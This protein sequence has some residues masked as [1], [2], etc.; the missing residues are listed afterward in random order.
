MSIFDIFRKRKKIPTPWAKYYNDEELD[1]KI[2]NIS[3][4]KQLSI[5]ANR[6]PNNIAYRYLGR[7]VSYKKF[8]KQIDT[9]AI[10]FKKMEIKKGDVVTICLPNLP[11]A[12]IAFYALNKLG[13][14]ASMIHPLSAE[15]EIK[16]SVISTKSKYL[17]ILDMFYDKVKNTIKGTK[18]RNVIFASASNSMSL[19]LKIGYKLINIGKLKKYPRNDF[20]MSW[21][22]FINKSKFS[23]LEIKDKYGK[24]TP[25]VILHSGGTSGK[26]KN[27]VLQ[28]RSF[29]MS[30]IQEGVCLKIANVGDSILAI[31][32]NFH[33]FGLSVCMH[34]VMTLGITSI[35]VPQFD[36][37]KFDVLF[38]K[39]KP[40]IVVGVPTL[41]E[42]LISNNNVKKLD[43]SYLKIAISG[44]DMLSK[45]LEDRVNNYFEEHN[46]DAKITQG[47]GMTEALAAVCLGIGDVS[48]SG[49]IG[50]PLPGNHIKIINPSTRKTNPYNV[51]GEI[52]INTKALMMGYLNNETETNE[53]LQIHDDGHVW[54]HSGDLG[55]MDEDGF[56]F[57]KGRLKRMIITSGYNVYPSHIEEV[58][59][60]HPAVLQCTVVGVPHPYKQEVPKAFIVLKEGYHSLFVKG[61]IKEYCKKNL[62]KYMVPHEFV[63]RKKLPK[64]KIGKVDFKKLESDI[65]KDDE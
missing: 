30:A 47:Y 50:I 4:Y 6:Y 48:K 38:N 18:V 21:K 31:M 27:V 61:E 32:P 26:P 2:P 52:C 45:S 29:V 1:I 58:I 42:A 55:Y 28:N 15:E 54:L 59:E 53:A 7:N 13:A 19:F 14:I 64:T 63:Y 44:G 37:K 16:E 36:S 5:T 49:S 43:L 23:K 56:V 25:A 12:L 57:C 41:F 46:S 10:S 34:S 62:A 65:G 51:V 39:N 11:E 60:A 17:I 20:F 22:K 3:I 35:L 40:T 8:M 33:G 9:A 24:D